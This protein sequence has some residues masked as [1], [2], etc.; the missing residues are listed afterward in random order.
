MALRR[1]IMKPLNKNITNNVKRLKLAAKGGSLTTEA[2][3]RNSDIA[4]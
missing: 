2:I 3:K 4:T 1:G